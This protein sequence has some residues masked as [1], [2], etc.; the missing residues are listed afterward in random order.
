[1]SVIAN[2]REQRRWWTV[3]APEY[4]AQK[5]EARTIKG[6][7]ER[8]KGGYEPHWQ[9][10][11]RWSDSF[12]NSHPPCLPFGH[13]PPPGPPLWP[14]SGV[15]WVWVTDVSHTLHQPP[16]ARLQ[17]H[18]PRMIKISLITYRTFGS[19][20]THMSH[21]DGSEA[22]VTVCFVRSQCVIVFAVAHRWSRHAMSS[23]PHTA[24]VAIT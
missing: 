18:P 7:G 24:V 6:K 17:K 1:M 23:S 16:R 22:F 8:G 2:A 19:V 14:V 4:R 15:N 20:K 13:P 3:T 12:W 5:K 9:Q 11:G 21:K 10:E